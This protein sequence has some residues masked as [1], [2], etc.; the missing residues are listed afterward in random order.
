MVESL[1]KEC[2]FLELEDTLDGIFESILSMTFKQALDEECG[3][4]ISIR[5]QTWMSPKRIT[6]LVLCLLEVYE[7]E[8]DLDEFLD[9]I[10]N[11]DDSEVED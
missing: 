2:D 11:R 4:Y 10:R 9:W 5:Y 3:C 1:N 7:D 6:D 8:V